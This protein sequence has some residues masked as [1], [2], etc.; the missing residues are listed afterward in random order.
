VAGARGPRAAKRRR[1]FGIALIG[2]LV[3]HA[4][5]EYP[6][7]YM[8]FLLPAMFVFGLLETRPLRL[9]PGR[10][11]FGAFA[12]VVFGGLAALYPVY[13]DYT[14]AEVLYYGSRPAEQYQAAPSFLFGVGRV[15]P[16]D[17]AADE[18]DEPATQARDAQAGDCAATR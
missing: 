8:F 16:R 10:L 4:L 12:V 14:R 9:V 3:M 5:V 6:Q 15:R 1:V 2:V 11:S 7:Q 17:A 13:R 18:L